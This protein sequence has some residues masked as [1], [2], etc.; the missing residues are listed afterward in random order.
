MKKILEKI[1]H[2]FVQKN[3]FLKWLFIVL[4]VEYL[5]L[6]SLETILPGFVTTVFNLNLLL[7]LV[8]ISW[9]VS[10]FFTKKDDQPFGLSS[11]FFRIILAILAIVVISSLFFVLYKTKYWETSIYL[12]FVIVAGKI[13]HDYLLDSFLERFSKK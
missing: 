13:L 1:Y 11:W 10:N 8:M 5:F 3:D 2:Y 4:A 9:V 12:F 7:L 6:F